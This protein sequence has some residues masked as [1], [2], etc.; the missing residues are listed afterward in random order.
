MKIIA[1]CPNFVIEVVSIVI[2]LLCD[3]S[4][5]FPSKTSTKQLIKNY[6]ASVYTLCMSPVFIFPDDSDRNL[7]LKVPLTLFVSRFLSLGKDFIILAP[8]C[9]TCR[10]SLQRRGNPNVSHHTS[11]Q[12]T[13]SEN[14]R[15]QLHCLLP[16]L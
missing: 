10:A 16:A 7:I 5:T 15:L 4:Q 8:V 6:Y 3:D 12:T 11:I 1:A 13:T 14:Q 2:L 9:P